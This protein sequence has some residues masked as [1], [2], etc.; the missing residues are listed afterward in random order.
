[1]IKIIIVDDQ[2]IIREGIKSLVQQDSEIEVV[3]CAE[4]GQDAFELCEKHNPDLVLMDLGMPICDGV[5]GTKL[6]KT[7]FPSIKVIILTTFNDDESIKKALQNGADGYILKDI[8]PEELIFTVKSA[9]MGIKIVHEDIL[10]SLVGQIKVSSLSKS[11]N[12]VHFTER[13]LEIIRCIVDGMD[14]KEIANK[15]FISE[16]SVRNAISGI[17]Q[18]LNLKDRVQI[19]VYA[20]KNDLV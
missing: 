20:V 11:E 13:E 4:N 16:G 15:L 14:N 3:A 18:K 7:K 1:M 12:K 8:N 10:S 6:I 2:N 17:F 9:S 5:E 19:A